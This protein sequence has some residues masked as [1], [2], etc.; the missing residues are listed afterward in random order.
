MNVCM[1]LGSLH[2][3]VY[4]NAAWRPNLMAGNRS[5]DCDLTEGRTPVLLNKINFCKFHFMVGGAAAW[6]KAGVTGI[7]GGGGKEGH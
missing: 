3:H 2:A 4:H 1:S 7:V 6:R 5:P